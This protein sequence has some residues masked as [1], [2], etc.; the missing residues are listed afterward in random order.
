MDILTDPKFAT[1]SKGV[2][3]FYKRW[4]E[5]RQG[6]DPQTF[7]ALEGLDAEV[8]GARKLAQQEGKDFV[9]VLQK[10]YG[11]KLKNIAKEDLEIIN[12]ALGKVPNPG[13]GASK[14]ILKIFGKAPNKRTPA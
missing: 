11:T 1:E 9:R 13:T 7:R 8:R 10:E 2:K 4:I 5:S 3:G 14:Q 6:F 12:E